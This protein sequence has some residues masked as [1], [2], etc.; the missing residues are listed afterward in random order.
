M[1]EWI[2]VKCDEE[3]ESFINRLRDTEK[4]YMSRLNPANPDYDPDMIEYYRGKAHGLKLA[5]GLVDSWIGE[6]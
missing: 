3:K 1:T 6:F 5:I 2:N 4:V